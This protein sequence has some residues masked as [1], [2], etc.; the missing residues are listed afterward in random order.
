MTRAHLTI[1]DKIENIRAGELA[2]EDNVLSFCNGEP[3]FSETTVNGEKVAVCVNAKKPRAV[4]ATTDDGQPLVC[5]YKYGKGEIV[6]F[7]TKAYPSENAIRDLYEGEMQ[8][9]L[10]EELSKEAV[11]AEGEDNVE[12]AVYDQ[13]DGSRHRTREC[14]RRYPT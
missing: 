9:L 1:T 5:V 12:F 3:K 11:W 4:L 13:K 10:S 2:F 7:N 6:L 14:S 8:R